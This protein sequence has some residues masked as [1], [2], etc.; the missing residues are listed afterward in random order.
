MHQLQPDVHRGGHL[1]DPGRI[2]GHRHRGSVLLHVPRLCAA[3]FR[4]DRKQTSLAKG[5]FVSSVSLS[6][7]I[8]PN[9]IFYSKP[10]QVFILKLLNKVAFIFLFTHYSIQ[11][12]VMFSITQIELLL[13]IFPVSHFLY[14]AKTNII[15]FHY[16]AD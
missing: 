7:F 13:N 8:V 9:L 1:A 5:S 14:I 4:S 6:T 12:T 2:P 10:R 3:V 11:S 15:Y 16:I